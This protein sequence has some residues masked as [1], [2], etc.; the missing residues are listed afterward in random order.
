MKQYLKERHFAEI[1]EVQQ[2]LMVALGQHFRS[3]F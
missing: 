1:A 2:E 3:G